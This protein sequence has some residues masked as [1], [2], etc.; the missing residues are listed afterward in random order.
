MTTVKPAS[1]A[2]T[3]AASP[4]RN[5]TLP[6][7]P[8]NLTSSLADLISSYSAL[9]TNA[10]ATAEKKEEVAPEDTITT[11]SD[12]VRYHIMPRNID[13]LGSDGELLVHLG[14]L[15]H[16]VVDRCRCREG[17]YYEANEILTRS[18]MPTFLLPGVIMTS[19]IVIV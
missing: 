4:A 11:F 7:A 6:L 9:S 19:I 3:A 1:D 10:T 13:Q 16:A 2:I 15:Q 14:D 18:R 12:E 17:A 5:I 8:Q